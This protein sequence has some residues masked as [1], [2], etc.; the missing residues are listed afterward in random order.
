VYL[1]CFLSVEYL[2]SKWTCLLIHL[3]FMLYFPFSLSLAYYFIFFSSVLEGLDLIY[4]LL[5]VD[6]KFKMCF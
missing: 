5:V 2:L 3:L 4:I 1:G 6:S